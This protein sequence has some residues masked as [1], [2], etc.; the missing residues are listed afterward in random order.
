[1]LQ[2]E[3]CTVQEEEKKYLNQYFMFMKGLF[4]CQFV[5][6]IFYFNVQ[7][8]K[9]S[10]PVNGSIRFAHTSDTICSYARSGSK[11]RM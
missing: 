3:F 9:L 8:F 5:L 1:M 10:E 11:C 6:L 7:Y 4:A 2:S